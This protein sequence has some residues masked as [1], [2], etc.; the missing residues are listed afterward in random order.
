MHKAV[1]FDLDGTLCDMS[2]RLC[3][4]KETPKKWEAFN[5][6]S[7]YDRP[8]WS[9]VR[10][11]LEYYAQ[12]FTVI[13]MTGRGIYAQSITEAWLEKHN[14]P[15]HTLIM[16]SRND[17]SAQSNVKYEFLLGLKKDGI[18]VQAIYD[19]DITVCTFLKEKGYNVHKVPSLNFQ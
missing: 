6:L 3:K 1:V 4:I 19:D 8:I 9:T 12:D 5:M 7:Q 17:S 13:L 14:I 10:K 11:L 16:R 18:D 2:W 15:Y